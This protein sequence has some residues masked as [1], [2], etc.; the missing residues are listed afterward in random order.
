MVRG[1]QLQN[2]DLRAPLRLLDGGGA[3]DWQRDR[4]VLLRPVRSQPAHGGHH[5]RLLWHGQHRR[6]PLRRLHVRLRGAPLRHA[7]PPLEPLDPADPRRCLLP[8]ARPRRIPPHIHL[9]HGLLLHLRP[10]RL[11]RHLRRHSLHLSPLPRRHQRH[12]RRRGQLR[13]RSHPAPILHQR[14]VLHGEGAVA[15]GRHD[16]GVHDA[17]GAGALPAVGQHVPSAVQGLDEL[18]GGALLREGVE[19]GGAGEGHAP[20]KLKI[21]WEQPVRAR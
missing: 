14:Q 9:L 5:R 15:D 7:R 3:D 20:G 2:V 4:R 18:N 13:L 21:C 10:G 12:D 19:Q 17:S 8:L 16:H 1:D 11:R 6:P